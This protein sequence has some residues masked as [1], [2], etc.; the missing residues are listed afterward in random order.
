[1]AEDPL[2]RQP[3]EIDRSSI[4]RDRNQGQSLR[5]REELPRLPGYDPSRRL[6]ANNACRGCH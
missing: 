4:L 2:G 6:P 5:Q 1:M 3:L